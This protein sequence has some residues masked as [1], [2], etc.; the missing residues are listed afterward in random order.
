MWRENI[1]G[2]FSANIIL[3]GYEKRGFCAYYSRDTFPRARN[4]RLANSL[5]SQTG[6]DFPERLYNGLFFFC[7]NGKTFS[8]LGRKV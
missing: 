4:E 7:N 2:Y 6:I 5:P 8:Q 1:L 3:I